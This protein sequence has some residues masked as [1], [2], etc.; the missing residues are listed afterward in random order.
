MERGGG[1]PQIGVAGALV[2]GVA[3]QPTLVPKL[4]DRLDCL[5]VEALTPAV[6]P[7]TSDGTAPFLGLHAAT[8][9]TSVADAAGQ[10]Q[11][12]DDDEQDREHHHLP[13]LGWV[14]R[15]MMCL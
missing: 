14:G 3:R 12:Y 2:E 11:D 15:S 8:A 9:A 4:G 7:A 5:P 1:D 6:P 13:R 10:Q